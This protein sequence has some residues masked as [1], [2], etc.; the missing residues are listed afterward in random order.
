M[1]DEPTSS[2]AVASYDDDFSNTAASAARPS[3]R[4]KQMRDGFNRVRVLLLDDLIRN[5]DILVYAQLS[6]LYYLE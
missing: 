5:L 3:E 4:R 6:A 1:S 2:H